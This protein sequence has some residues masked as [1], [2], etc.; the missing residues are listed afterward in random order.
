MPPGRYA[1]RLLVV[2]AI[3]WTPTV[4]TGAA[5]PYRTAFTRWRAADDSFRA[6]SLAGVRLAPDGSL[7][8]D[9]ATA[10]SGRDQPGAY[11]R[12]NFYNGGSFL[13]GEAL[14]PVVPTAFGFH[15]AIASWNADTPAGTWIETRIRARVGNRWTTWYN[16]GVWA[17]DT[18]TVERHSVNLQA[19]ADGR[20]SVDTLVL[21]GK[22]GVAR[23]FQLRLRLFSASGNR[24]RA[25]PRV[26]A[27]SV[28]T[29]T[30]RAAPGA[31]APGNP[32][33][34]NTLLSVPACSQMI[35]RDG[36]EIWCSP[37]SLSMVLAYWQRASGPCEPR[38]RAAVAGVYDW[39][40][41]G[42]GNWP[43]SVAYAA[44]QQL[45]GY[46]ARFTSLAE[47][48]AWIGA[49]VPVVISFSW[50]PGTLDG[51]P[52]KASTGHISVLVGFDAA[53][54]PIVN[55]PAASANGSVQRTYARAQLE[56]LWL[57]HAGGTVYL[58]YPPGH[59][60]PRFEGS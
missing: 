13:V 1:I 58:L 9:R 28:A 24:Q 34:W 45:E 12:R 55:D 50:K 53:G 14:S 30:P 59:A 15:E 11:S 39:R 26:R 48:E 42:Y 19:D 18:S 10:R 4:A 51:A 52:I 33:R 27:A 54:N 32:A 47:A 5:T 60:V 56:R 2:L 49:G 7:N 44:T 22:H 36:G 3:L 21:S 46:V 17:A 29:S 6:W 40:Y 20:V 57:E 8:L 38:V 41:D 31:L 16:L 25:V 43:F 35:Y 37:T 23:A